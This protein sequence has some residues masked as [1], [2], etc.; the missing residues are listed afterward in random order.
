MWHK[1]FKSPKGRDERNT[2]ILAKFMEDK[3]G[4]HKKA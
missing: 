2:L 4:T 1:I 3:K